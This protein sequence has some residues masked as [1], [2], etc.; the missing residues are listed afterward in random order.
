[1]FNKKNILIIVPWLPYPLISGGHQAI[2]NGIKAICDSHNVI[3]TYAKDKEEDFLEYEKQMLSEL[4]HKVSIVPFVL[5]NKPEQKKEKIR[6][7]TK[8]HRKLDHFYFR[9]ISPP[10]TIIRPEY[11]EWINEIRP[12]PNEYGYHILHLIDKYTI[13]IV[14]CEMIPTAPCVYFLPENV[15]KVFI[16]HELRFVC[17]QLITDSISTPPLDLF[18]YQK[19]AMATEIGT[20]NYFDGVVTLS[21]TDRDKLI[22][23]RL[24]T[25]IYTSFA[26]INSNSC[27]P[28]NCSDNTTLTF[29]GPE[30]H[31]PNSIG[32][33]WFLDNCWEELQKHGKYHLKIIGM[34]S[35]ETIQKISEKYKNVI[36]TGYVDNLVQEIKN[37][38][39]IVP[40]TIGSG[41]RM[42][43]LEAVY[44]GI[45]FVST[46]VGLEGIPLVNMEHCM[47]ADESQ[48]F[49]NAILML[50][51]PEFSNHLC[52]NAQDV[53]LNKYSVEK[54]KENRLTI[55]NDLLEKKNNLNDK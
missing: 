20:L 45:P 24:N 29:I 13:N 19:K 4:N 40:I 31:S 7:K 49:V 47:I 14:Q 2:F 15:I 44:A 25:S 34:W 53:I 36:F 38:I 18:F 48:S 9:H 21:S 42:K 1:M 6:F 27:P 26:I 54:L 39:F 12:I 43:I 22:D 37:T 51:D 17:H 30:H 5:N 46:S 33:M 35:E 32:I 41:I 55:Y 23:A 16:H 3:I 52:K 11:T 8:I 28:S 50:R 10:H